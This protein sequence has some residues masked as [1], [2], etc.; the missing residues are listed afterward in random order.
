MGPAEEFG[1]EVE[2]PGTVIL[3]SL[4]DVEEVA[5]D[6]EVVVKGMEVLEELV[7]AGFEIVRNTVL[8]TEEEKLKELDFP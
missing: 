7:A 1:T 5:S 3:G 4:D 6:G 2:I 8:N